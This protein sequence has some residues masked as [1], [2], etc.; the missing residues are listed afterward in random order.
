MLLPMPE[1]IWLLTCGSVLSSKLIRGMSS[2]CSFREL[3]DCV[4]P[5]LHQDH[6]PSPV[7]SVRPSL[8]SLPLFVPNVRQLLELIRFAFATTCPL[9]K[10]PTRTYREFFRPAYECELHI[11]WSKL[12]QQLDDSVDGN[13]TRLSS[14]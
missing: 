9:A 11:R 12:Q 6:W 10:L 5:V 14:D 8:R 1:S 3:P 7:R 2:S 4:C 13:Y